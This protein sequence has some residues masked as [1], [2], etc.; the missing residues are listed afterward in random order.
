MR[1]TGRGV[2]PRCPGLG[3]ARWGRGR[4]LTPALAPGLGLA[5]APGTAT[6]P[7]PQDGPAKG[8]PGLAC[9]LIGGGG[10]WTAGEART[11]RQALRSPQSAP[12]GPAAGKPHQGR[13]ARYRGGIGNA[14]TEQAGGPGVR[15]GRGEWAP[16]QH[17]PPGVSFPTAQR[18]G[19]SDK[20]RVAPWD[21]EAA[22][23]LSAKN[24]D[25][26]EPKQCTRMGMKKH[27]P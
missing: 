9:G 20:C 17:C 1:A 25:P 3:T 16:S 13:C 24:L 21:A 5:R 8:G 22:Q 7:G 15:R 10:G 18:T 26:L 14:G 12:R 27:P 6:Y 11:T 19:A 2:R 23:L 4:E